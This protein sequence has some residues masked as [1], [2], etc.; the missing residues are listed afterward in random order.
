M[1]KK[2]TRMRLVT[3]HMPESYIEG[4][5][6]LIEQKKYPT[7]S[8]AVRAAVRY[9]LKRELYYRYTVNRSTKMIA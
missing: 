6:E 4:L 7:I 9:F 5:K 2:G 8:E 3:V 1:H